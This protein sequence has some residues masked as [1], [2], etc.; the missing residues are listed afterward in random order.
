M[1]FAGLLAFA[2]APMER[3]HKKRG[4]RIR[5]RAGLWIGVVV[6]LVDLFFV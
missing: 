3:T 6:A 5:H 2:L 1:I 4:F